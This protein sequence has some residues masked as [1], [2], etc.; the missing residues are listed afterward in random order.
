MQTV[1]S[2]SS[3]VNQDLKEEHDDPSGSWLIVD[4]G[5]LD[6]ENGHVPPIPLAHLSLLCTLIQR[7]H[8]LSSVKA[9]FEVSQSKAWPPPTLGPSPQRVQITSDGILK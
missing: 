6:P 5:P 9:K 2:L 4:S 8:I 3:Y 1:A 7:E